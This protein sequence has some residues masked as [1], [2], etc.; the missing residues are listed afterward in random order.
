[1]DLSPVRPSQEDDTCRSFELTRLDPMVLKV[2]VRTEPLLETLRSEYVSN[3]EYA[4]AQ[5]HVTE[6]GDASEEEEE[7]TS[8]APSP[9]GAARWRIAAAVASA[10]VL[11]SARAR[12]RTHG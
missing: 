12:R 10:V 2:R 4:Y 11:H 8:S 7:T 9:P 6:L 5:D 1:M 3:C